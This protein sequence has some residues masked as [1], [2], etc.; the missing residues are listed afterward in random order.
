MIASFFKKKSFLLQ[1]RL[2]WVLA[3]I[4][5]VLVFLFFKIVP[6]GKVTYIKH[7]PTGFYFGKGFINNF[8]PIENIG[9]YKSV[10]RIIKAPVYFSVFT[11]RTFSEARITIKYKSYL[12]KKNLGE[13]GVLINPAIA[14]YNLQP[15]KL[16]NS[17]TAATDI[18]LHGVYRSSGKY[19]FTISIPE[20][21]NNENLE[22][23]LEVSEV[24]IEFFGRTLLQKIMGITD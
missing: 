24:K 6:F 7:Y 2:F 19:V 23:Y 14:Y 11:P 20:L 22:N 18:D 1:L 21:E 15:W 9:S 12:S 8:T 4:F 16:I 10:P 3:I 5:I 17:D 13:I